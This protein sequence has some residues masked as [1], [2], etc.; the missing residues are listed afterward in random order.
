MDGRSQDAELQIKSN[1]RN[2]AES[3]LEWRFALY[4][5]LLPPAGLFGYTARLITSSFVFTVNYFKL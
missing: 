4:S 2:V 1:R 3:R 5:H